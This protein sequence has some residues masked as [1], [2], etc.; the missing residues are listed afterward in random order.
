MIIEFHETLSHNANL[1]FYSFEVT[2]LSVPLFLLLQYVYCMYARTAHRLTTVRQLC[3]DTCLEYLYCQSVTKNQLRKMKEKKINKSSDTKINHYFPQKKTKSELQNRAIFLKNRLQL[4]S[5]SNSEVNEPNTNS[6]C[7]DCEQKIKSL[8]LEL[9]LAK[10]KIVELEKKN[11]DVRDDCKKLKKM[12]TASIEINLHKDLQINE[13]S[14]QPGNLYSTFSK[15]LSVKA[16]DSLRKIPSGK[17]ND[18]TTVKECLYHLHKNNLS[19]LSKR[20]VFDRPEKNI[21]AIS[22]LKKEIIKNL[23]IERVKSETVS[24]EEITIRSQ[25]LDDHIRNGINNI[26]RSAEF[27]KLAPIE[28][29]NIIQTETEAGAAA[30]P[31]QAGPAYVVYYTLDS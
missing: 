27:K 30:A 25:K 12:Y 15:D 29:A 20:G 22:P 13:L 17:K 23:L 16:L 2:D 19:I 18:S 1:Y 4:E 11:K 10:K 7:I 26:V 3:I 28:T 9:E 6:R 5:D 31:V 24:S 14:K 8:E 21:K